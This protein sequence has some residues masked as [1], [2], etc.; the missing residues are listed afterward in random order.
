ML[1]FNV[2]YNIII[3]TQNECHPTSLKRKGITVVPTERG[4]VGD[5]CGEELIPDTSKKKKKT[6]KPIEPPLPDPFPLPQNFRPDVELALKSGNMTT[7]TRK[8]YLSQVASAIFGYKKYPIREEFMRVADQII[9]R[10]PFLQS[11]MPGGSKTVSD[12]LTY[13]THYNF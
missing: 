9:R 13:S 11:P 1:H 10:Y 7:N 6:M 8:A 2:Y 12:L 4:G 3:Y 5:Y